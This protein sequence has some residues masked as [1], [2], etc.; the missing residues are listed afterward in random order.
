MRK[1]TSFL[2]IMAVLAIALVWTQR[3][4]QA[5]AAPAPATGLNIAVVNVSKI[6]TDCKEY[7]DHEKQTAQ[8][9]EQIKAKLEQLSKEIESL[10]KEIEVALEPGSAE[11]LERLQ[12]WINKRALYQ[13]YSDGQKQ[14]L[15]AEHQAWAETLYTKLLEEVEKIAQAEGIDL[16]LNKDQSPLNTRKLSDLLEVIR[17]RKVLYSTTE[18][19]LTDKVLDSLNQRYAAEK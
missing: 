15:E 6:L 18:L 1:T 3:A 7:A 11:Y 19:D 17:G 8:K 4:P 5:Q 9:G 14:V 2:A 12:E 10:Q 16:I 13:A